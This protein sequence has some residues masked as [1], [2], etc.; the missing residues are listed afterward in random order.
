MAEELAQNEEKTLPATP[1]RLRQLRERGQ[2]PRSTELSTASVLLA[3]AGAFFMFGRDI[4]QG[5]LDLMR[6]AFTAIPTH[7]A[8]T[9]DLLDDVLFGLVTSVELLLPVFV[10]AMI[11]SFIG[12]LGVGGWVF[13]AEPLR[14]KWEK[15]DP[16]KGMKRRIFSVRGL[17]EMAKSLLKFVVIAAATT[18][19][20]FHYFADSVLFGR[21]EYREAISQ[22][23]VLVLIVFCLL[24]VSTLLIAAIDIPLQRFNFSRENRMSHSEVKRELRNEEGIPEVRQRIRQQQRE[25]AQRRMM[26]AVPT[27]DV[28]IT[29]PTHVAVAL[30]YATGASAPTLVASGADNVAAKIRDLALENA[31]P[32][33]ESPPLARSIFHHTKLNQEIP[34]GLYAAVAA[35]LGYAFRLAGR[36]GFDEAPLPSAALPIPQELMVAPNE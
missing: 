24:C 25:I 13:S 27:A 31:V 8:G 3:V 35:V 1:G 4:V 20:L 9:S 12:P 26:E 36:T 15:L 32:V 16:F 7:L 19:V 33:I 10:V 14:F 21:M 2:V 11:A 6:S 18:A 30:K 34:I 5:L 22:A 28:V 29:N 23:G 17:F